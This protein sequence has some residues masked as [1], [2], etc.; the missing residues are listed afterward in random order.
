MADIFMSYAHEDRP[1]ARGLAEAL[2]VVA[3]WSVFWDRTIPPGLSWH[4]VIGKEF[5]EARC[6]IVAWSST[7]VRSDWVREEADEGK[8]RGV[9]LPV[10]LEQ[11]TAPVGF[12]SIQG[13]DLSNWDGTAGGSEFALLATA[14]SRIV[15]KATEQAERLARER[16]A[17]ESARLAREREVAEEARK[18]REQAERKARERAEA[19]RRAKEE[20]ERLAREQD[21]AEV[22]RKVREQEDAE[23]KAQEL[24][25]REQ[26][27][28]DTA[29]GAREQE[30]ARPAREQELERRRQATKLSALVRRLGDGLRTHPRL[31]LALVAF[32]VVAVVAV[33]VERRD[34]FTRPSA[35]DMPVAPAAMGGRPEM[36]KPDFSETKS[37][38]GVPSSVGVARSERITRWQAHGTSA[39]TGSENGDLPDP[40]T[41]GRGQAARCR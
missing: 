2:A 26:A 15:A 12:R 27:A 6:I 18:T 34:F 10:F 14:L 19:E 17:A 21:A 33:Y 31:A 25:E 32:A 5:E 23:R 41:T 35:N 38:S 39:S 8:R 37:P 7:S 30:A 4:E 28:G 22:A 9:L 24:L 40:R 36:S 20:A 16:E 1:R 3:N 29:R 11:V 13:V